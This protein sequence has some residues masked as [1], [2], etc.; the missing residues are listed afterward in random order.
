MA[1]I[2]AMRLVILDIDGVVYC[3]NMAVPGA[4]DAVEILLQQG[5]IVKFLTND[6]VSSRLSRV[7]ELNALGFNVHLSDIYTAASITA[8]YL[9]LL[10]S[11]RT[12]L[13]SGGEALEEFKGIPLVEHNPEIVVVGDYFDSY[14]FEKLNRAFLGIRKGTRFI[15]MQRN[16]HCSSGG[17]PT[18]D[19]GFWVSGLEYCTGIQAEVIGKPA[20]RSYLSICQE[21]EVIPGEAAMVSDDLSLD[22]MGAHNAGLITVHATDYHVPP[23]QNTFIH[24]DIVVPNLSTFAQL[25]SH[26]E[27]I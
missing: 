27:A 16:R 6:A 5:L 21:A 25:F 23:V 2:N 24:P 22:L 17:D 9:R 18:I 7:R 4:C 10:G 1:S 3:N 14:S 20:A 13:L 11:P 19:V 12:M 15:A 26:R 8:D